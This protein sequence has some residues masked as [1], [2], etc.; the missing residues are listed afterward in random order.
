MSIV[1]VG[2]RLLYS[3][4]IVLSCQSNSFSTCNLINQGVLLYLEKFK[5][6][7]DDDNSN[8]LKHK[9]QKLKY[10]AFAKTILS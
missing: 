6:H 8:G 5:R 9:R 2:N 3:F 4:L 7:E 1:L 10:Q